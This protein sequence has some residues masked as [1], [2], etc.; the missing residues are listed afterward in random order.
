MDA[1]SFPG[2]SATG[3]SD[4]RGTSWDEP[5]VLPTGAFF[6]TASERQDLTRR[7]KSVRE[8]LEGD[9]QEGL[10][11]SALAHACETRTAPLR[12]VLDMASARRRALDGL[13][14]VLMGPCS[15]LRIDLEPSM[16]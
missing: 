11:R 9:Q 13:G 10:T 8:W 3:Q 12:R 1:A 2:G 15:T 16:S 6:L 7:V 14:D 5:P 4:P